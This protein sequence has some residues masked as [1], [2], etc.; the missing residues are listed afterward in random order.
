MGRPRSSS[1]AAVSDADA[2]FAR[3]LFAVIDLFAAFDGNCPP[4]DALA[5]LT[6]G[7]FFDFVLFEALAS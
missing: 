2:C 7:C 6:V 3:A 4:V 1:S 5:F